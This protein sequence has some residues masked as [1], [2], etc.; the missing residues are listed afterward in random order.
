MKTRIGFVSNSSSSSFLVAFAVLP[1]TPEELQAM[2][3]DP[4]QTIYPTPWDFDEMEKNYPISKVVNTIWEDMQ[5]EEPI[6]TQDAVEL[7][8]CGTVDGIHK[9][10]KNCHYMDGSHQ[11][12]VSYDDFRDPRTNKTNWSA[13]NIAVRKLAEQV[14]AKFL[15]DNPGATVLKFRYSD[16]DSDYDAALEHGMVFDRLPHLTISHH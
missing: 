2:L 6:K 16:N 8:T 11:T 4:E 12:G 14:Y 13:Y 3:F 9:A 1:K 15:Q 5:G 7:L 10:G